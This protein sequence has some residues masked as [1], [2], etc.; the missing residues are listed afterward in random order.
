MIILDTD[1]LIEIFDKGSIKGDFAIS[2]L[3]ETGEDIAITS[4]NLHE[5][6]YGI[7]KYCKKKVKNLDQLET[8]AFTSE[9]ARLSAQLE[10]DCE[11]LGKPVS[12]I[13]SMIAG[14]VINRKAKLYTFNKKHFDNFDKLKMI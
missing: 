5:I 4:L 9:D 6:L 11:R 3:E 12:R 7:K 14:I 2:K 8:I 13:D 1:V 10:L